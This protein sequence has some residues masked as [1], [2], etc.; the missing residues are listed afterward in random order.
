MATVTHIAKPV[1]SRCEWWQTILTQDCL[2]TKY[3]TERAPF[4]Y[5][6]KN[7]DLELKEGT[8]L[9]D[10]EEIHHRKMRGYKVKLGMAIG[11]TVEWL[12]P[13]LAHKIYIKN[14]GGYEDLLA[15]SGDV[16]AALRLAIYLNN[17]E[18]KIK[19]FKKLKEF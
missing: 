18:D 5:L 10:S 4:K 16:A 6:K 8:L 3:L 15:G 7:S 9:I 2:Q 13:T 17:H 11:E 19:E 14:L 1:D 12:K